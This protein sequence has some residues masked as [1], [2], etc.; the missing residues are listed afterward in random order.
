M[1]SQEYTVSCQTTVTAGGTTPTKNLLILAAG[2]PPM[3]KVSWFLRKFMNITVAQRV[4]TSFTKR[5]ISTACGHQ[6][7]FA[8]IYEKNPL[9]HCNI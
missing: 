6:N 2:P 3:S 7:M 8:S 5:Y 4:S 1:W 9:S